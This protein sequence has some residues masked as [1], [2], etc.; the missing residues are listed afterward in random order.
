MMIKTK[1]FFSNV[2]ALA[3]VLA[4]GIAAILFLSLVTLH[5]V[6]PRSVATRNPSMPRLTTG[7]LGGSG[8]KDCGL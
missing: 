7:N 8:R 1:N 4:L 5:H 3:L 6:I 2:V